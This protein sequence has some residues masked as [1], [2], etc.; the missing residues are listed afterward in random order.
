[1]DPVLLM[2]LAALCGG[3]TLGLGAIVVGAEDR[4]RLQRSLAAVSAM[5]VGG[6]PVLV[7]EN[8]PFADRVVR[9]VF[10][11]M[12]RLGRR[13]SPG[14]FADKLQHRLDVAG[15]PTSMTVERV[16]ALKG[17]GLVLGAAFAVLVVSGPLALVLAAALGGAGFFV[18]D[19]LIYNAGVKRQEQIGRSLPDSLDLLSISVEAGLGFDAALSQ[20]SRAPRP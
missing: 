18:P 4:Q 8:P 13:L 5:R 10:A 14:G 1:M 6:A 9:P 15:N 7:Q 2:G 20:V 12:T 16:L 19:L 3:L 17:F 11:T